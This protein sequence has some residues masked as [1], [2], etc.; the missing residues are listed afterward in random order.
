MPSVYSINISPF[1]VLELT[2]FLFP[3]YRLLNARY[4]LALLSA[5]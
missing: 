4:S 5:F 1:L 3:F 2:S